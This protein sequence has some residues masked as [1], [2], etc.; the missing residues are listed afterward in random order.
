V[1]EMDRARRAG[2]LAAVCV[3]TPGC[4]R[5]HRVLVDAMARMRGARGVFA[6]FVGDGDAADLL[7]AIDA[8]GLAGRTRVHGAS[9]AARVLAAGADV[10]VLPSRSDAQPLAVLEA[11]CD[12]TFVIGC[13]LPELVEL[14]E[15]GATGLL[16]GVDDAASLATALDRLAAMP[17]AS[18]RAIT[19]RARLVHAARF[20]TA[21]MVASYDDLYRDARPA[22]ASGPAP[23][24]RPAA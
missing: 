14:I 9:G 12:G 22:S 3:G 23:V 19:N 15:D 4:G 7:R 18:R 24:V 6:V 10:L 16:C 13:G 17:D 5:N 11:Y 21:G 20:T 8:A 1:R 2:L